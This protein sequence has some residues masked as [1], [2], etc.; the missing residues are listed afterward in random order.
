MSKYIAHCIECD[1]QLTAN[2]ADGHMCE[3]KEE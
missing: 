3:R 2:N 1:Q